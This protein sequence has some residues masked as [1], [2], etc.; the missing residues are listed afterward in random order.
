M[1]AIIVWYAL[2]NGA[3]VCAGPMRI[4]PAREI[5]AFAQR[6]IPADTTRPVMIPD[7]SEDWTRAGIICKQPILE[8]WQKG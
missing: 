5:M 7:D 8:G 2:T 4:E 3:P 6:Q 1:Y